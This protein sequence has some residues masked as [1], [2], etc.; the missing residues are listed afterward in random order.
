VNTGYMLRVKRDGK[1][2]SLDIAE[3]TEHEI[4]VTMEAWPPDKLR[5]WIVSLVHFIQ[6]LQPIHQQIEHR[7]D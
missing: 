2:H 1:F 5:N 4:R 6:E 7:R 3:M